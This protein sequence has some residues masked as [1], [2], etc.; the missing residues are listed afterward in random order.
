MKRMPLLAILL[1]SSVLLPGCGKKTLIRNYYV[2]E[3]PTP[4]E[5]AAEI[6]PMPVNVDVRDFRVAK[7]FDQ[8]RIALRKASHELVYFYYHH[9]AVRPSYAVA[10]LVYDILDDRAVFQ[11]CTRGFSYNPD[12]IVS[13]EVRAIERLNRD[14]KEYAHVSAVFELLDAKTGLPRVRHEFDRM[15][16]LEDDRSMN[17]FASAVSVLLARETDGFIEKIID[18]LRQNQK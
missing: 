9:W 15:R 10:D 7:A 5:P 6:R 8:T 4:S 1:L 11:R 12:Y 2:L 13:G 14:K 17:T 3:A 18:Y 16:A